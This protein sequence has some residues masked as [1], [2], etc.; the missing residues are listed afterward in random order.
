M[1]GIDENTITAVEQWYEG[2]FLPAL[3]THFG[4]H[5]YLL[6]GVAS[7]G[8]FALMGPLY[9][10]LYQ[11]PESGKIINTIAPNVA[12]WIE[13]MNTPA[14]QLG[15]WLENDEIPET[16][17]PILTRI[18]AELFPV[19]QST[20]GLLETWRQQNS[21]TDIP[22]FIAKHGFDA[23]EKAAVDAFLCTINGLTAMQTVISDRIDRKDNRLVWSS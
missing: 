16:L 20:V 1:L 12:K 14:E 18:F 8:D 23:N 13:R 21:A 3:D 9:A 22:R 11:D 10:H 17:V 5:D 7:I 15:S 19:L 4:A 2:D 6:G